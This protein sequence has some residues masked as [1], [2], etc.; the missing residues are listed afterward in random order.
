MTSDF[1]QLLVHPIY[2]TP[3]KFNGNH[4]EFEAYEHK[5]T[6]PLE[7]G[8]AIFLL[9]KQ[10]DNFLDT[11]TDALNYRAHYQIDANVYEYELENAHPVEQTEIDFLRKNI[12]ANIPDN[13]NIILDIGCG[14]AWLAKHLLPKGKAIISTDIS[15]INPKKAIKNYPSKNHFGIVADVFELPFKEQSIDC[16]VASEI[17]EHVPDPKKFITCL[18]EV[19]K[20][21]GSLIITTPYNELIRT[22]LCLHCNKE[23]PHNAHLHSFTEKSFE[24]IILKEVRQIKIILLNSKLFV[25]ARLQYLLKF[26]PLRIINFFDRI[27][28]KT[29]GKKAYRMMVLL[30]K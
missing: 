3:L 5:E 21:D 10:K 15:D 25:Q 12:L 6:F 24:Q 1:L 19:L 23:T 29:T 4:N 18:L 14:G 28:I 7:E 9:K 22:S 27:F 26:L 2:K 11:N 30:K 17:I 20:P 16:I 8:V 13:A